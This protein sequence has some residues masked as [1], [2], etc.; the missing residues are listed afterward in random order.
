MLPPH[1]SST[2]HGPIAARHTVLAGAAP[3]ATHRIGPHCI[4]PR[5]H[6]LPVEHAAPGMHDVEHVPRP[7]HEPPVH[8][9][10]VAAKPSGAHDAVPVV[11]CSATS[12]A[13]AA[14]RHVNELGRSASSGHVGLVPSHCSGASHGP[15]EA[16]H[17]VPAGRPAQLTIP[18]SSA[19]TPEQHISPPAHSDARSQR[20]ATHIADSHGPATQLAA[21]HG[22]KQPVTGS[23]LP[24]VG[25][26][27]ESVHDASSGVC[28]HTRSPLHVSTVHDTPSSHSEALA[29]P[30][31]ASSVIVE[32][33]T[34]P[35]STAASMSPASCAGTPP[36]SSRGRAMQPIVGTQMS[37]PSQLASSAASRQMP[38]TQRGSTHEVAVAHASSRVHCGRG[39]I[40]SVPSTQLGE[41]HTPP[42]QV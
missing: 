26:Q 11:H 16:R 27:L 20:P 21:V 22:G 40:G 6:G 23:A 31:G 32:A 24:S 42:T 4:S 19:H 28:T 33:S 41:V 34:P 17:S 7:S 13:S 37:L 12:H 5:S 10:P 15:L 8:V 36:S 3:I 14:G 29:Q 2:S 25:A 30:I 18:Q 38:A 9:V 39:Q 1:V 35:P